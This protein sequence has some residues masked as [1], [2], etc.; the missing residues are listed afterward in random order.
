MDYDLANPP[1]RTFLDHREGFGDG[2]DSPRAYLEDCIARIEELDGEVKAFVV[3]NLS[4]AREAADAAAER[5]RAGAPLSAIDGMPIGIK[6]IIETRDMPTQM[7][8][9]IYDGWHSHRDAATVRALREAGAVIIG[10]TVT[11]EFATTTPGPT[12]NP[13]D[14]ARTPGGSSSGSAAAVGVGMI[15]AALGTQVV[16]SILRPSS[17]CGCIGFK[18]TVGAINRGGSHDALSQSCHGVIAASLADNWAVMRA[19]ADRAGGDPGYPGLM[20]ADALATAVRPGKL[21]RLDTGGWSNVEDVARDQFEATIE[22]LAAAGVEIITR[23]DDA[24]VEALEAAIRDATPITRV[25][26]AWE[27]RWPLNDYRDREVDQLSSHMHKRLDQAE[28]MTLDDYRASLGEREAARDA[29]RGLAA[30]ADG[31]VTLAA[32][33][34]APLGLASTGDSTFNSTASLL[35]VPAITLPVMEADGLPLGLQLLG[36]H[37][38]DEKLFAHA[39][40]VMQALG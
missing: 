20:G 30:A 18:P 6:D 33:G 29:W 5:Y 1:L 12:H 19:M 2:N 40:W 32:T 34:P 16:G 9:P 23:S 15:P 4:G 26:N 28:A 8:S 3:L 39:G 21:I 36:F 10:K 14:A 17:Y 27:S 24:A 13:F 22:R 37:D 11:T 7:G 31:F 38:G 35:G 25:V